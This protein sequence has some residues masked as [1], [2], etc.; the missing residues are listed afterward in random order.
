MPEFSRVQMTK[1]DNKIFKNCCLINV[2]A[3]YLPSIES[4]IFGKD[5]DFCC[6]IVLSQAALLCHI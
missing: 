5:W 4:M 2:V 1:D 3:L 6:L